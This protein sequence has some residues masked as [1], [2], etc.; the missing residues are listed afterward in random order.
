MKIK[1]TPFSHLALGARFMYV[2]D[3]Q[4]TIWVKI[5]PDLVAKWDYHEQ[6]TSWLGQPV[7]S[8]GDSEKDKEVRH[9]LEEMLPER[10]SNLGPGP[11]LY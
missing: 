2:D 8:F 11:Q 6:D 4:N 1:N 9:I 3:A 7:C 5:Y 10:S